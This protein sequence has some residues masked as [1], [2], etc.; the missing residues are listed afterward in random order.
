[1]LMNLRAEYYLQRLIGYS[2][3]FAM[4]LTLRGAVS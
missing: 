2:K 1:M 4:S 3:W